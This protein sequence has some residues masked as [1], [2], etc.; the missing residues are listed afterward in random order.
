MKSTPLT[1]LTDECPPFCSGI[2]RSRHAHPYATAT[3][4]R[5]T[6][7]TTAPAHQAREA[8]RHDSG[9][10]SEDQN[11]STRAATRGAAE[12][13]VIPTEDDDTGG[14]SSDGSDGTSIDELREQVRRYQSHG[15][16][17]SG[18]HRAR[19]ELHNLFDDESSPQPADATGESSRPRSYYNGLHRRQEAEHLLVNDRSRRNQLDVLTRTRDARRRA[20]RR[21]GGAAV[22]GEE[23]TRL[24]DAEDR[25]I[26]TVRRELLLSRAERARNYASS[27]RGRDILRHGIRDAEDGVRRCIDCNWEIENGKCEHW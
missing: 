4:T 8:N 5:S 9:R 25:A 3:G 10:R 1:A 7:Q 11:G 27:S 18:E 14:S 6:A 24:R 23:E 26:A 15:D 13:I 19:A 16:A 17:L 22:R 20:H 12:P 21:A 2:G